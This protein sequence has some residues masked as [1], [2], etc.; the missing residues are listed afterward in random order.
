MFLAVAGDIRE[1]VIE[2]LTLTLNRI[3]S[4]ATSKTQVFA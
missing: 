2:T 3:K 4:E 1:R